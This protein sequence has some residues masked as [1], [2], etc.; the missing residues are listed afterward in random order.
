MA[1]TNN[2]HCQVVLLFYP[3]AY[4]EEHCLDLALRQFRQ[5]VL[6]DSSPRVRVVVKRQYYLLV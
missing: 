5:R 2:R 4:Q 6:R 3:F 1:F